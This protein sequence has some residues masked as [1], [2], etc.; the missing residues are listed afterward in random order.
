M[1]FRRFAGC[2]ALLEAGTLS[3][4]LGAVVLGV[5]VGLNGDGV[6]TERTDS[7][8]DA[9]ELI[10]LTGVETAGARSSSN[11]RFWGTGVGGV[12][13]SIMIA[14]ARFGGVCG[15]IVRDERDDYGCG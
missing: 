15:S 10:A 1:S 14:T 2:A 13:S 5:A 9:A 11:G 8:V 6:C 3:L 7:G 4:L 12:G